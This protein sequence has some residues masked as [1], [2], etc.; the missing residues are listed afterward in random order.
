VL[1]AVYATAAAPAQRHSRALAPA[2]FRSIGNATYNVS[3]VRSTQNTG[4]CA[5]GCTTAAYHRAPCRARLFSQLFVAGVSS[6][7]FM[8]NQLHVAFSASVSGAAIFSAGPYFCSQA[9]LE[10]AFTECM[11]LLPIDTTGLEQIAAIWAQ[12]GLI[13]D[14]SNLVESRVYLF[15]GNSDTVVAEAVMGSLYNMYQEEG[16]DVLYNNKTNA[17]HCWASPLGGNVC[18]V[19]QSPF[20]NNCLDDPQAELLQHWLPDRPLRPSSLMRPENLVAVSQDAVAQQLYLQDA[21]TFGMDHTAYAYVPDQCASGARCTLVIVLHGC[22]SNY[23][24]VGDVV[25]Y[26]ANVNGQGA[27]AET[28]CTRQRP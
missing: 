19:F 23:Q 25:L 1:C 28:R 18:D 5:T 17:A 27:E 12:Q 6:G 24:T 20:I 9:S 7:G 16:V 15:R 26:E 8:A 13:D 10:V 11:G 4:H 21:A 2:Q 14:L 3:E 22:L